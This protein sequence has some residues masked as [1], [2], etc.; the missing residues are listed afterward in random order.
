YREV[1]W[2]DIPKIILE[3]AVT[4]SIVLLLVGASMGM[5]WAMANADIPYMI[6]DAL[7]AISDNPMMIL[8]IINIILL[9]VGI[10]MD[11]TPAV[12]IFTPIF[13]PIALDMGID[14]VHFGIMMTFN[15]AIGICTP[16]VGSALFIGCSVANVAIDKVIKPLLPFYVALIAALMA[17][18][19]IPELS[20]FLPK[21]VLGY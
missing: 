7:L 18:T 13:L 10:F 11:M 16:P 5:S 12:L 20:L 17:V 19:F 21:L 14:P 15:L 9:I 3:S 4:T 8:L 1:K 6:A 2:R